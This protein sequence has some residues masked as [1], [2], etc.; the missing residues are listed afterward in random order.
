MLDAY[1][2]TQRT[3]ALERLLDDPDR[4]IRREVWALALERELGD[5]L[6][7]IYDNLG[8]ARLEG[9]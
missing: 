7:T 6:W 1:T 9:V 5:P 8:D 4:A 2:P 3:R